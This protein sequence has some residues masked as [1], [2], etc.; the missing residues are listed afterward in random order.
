MPTAIAGRPSTIWL[1]V[2]SPIPPET[3]LTLW[4]RGPKTYHGRIA[5]RQSHTDNIQAHF[6]VHTPGEYSL[7]VEDA[8]KHTLLEETLYVVAPF[9][10]SAASELAATEPDSHLLPLLHKH[11]VVRNNLE[12]D[13]ASAREPIKQRG[14]P[15]D[16]RTQLR[17][18][19]PSCNVNSTS[20]LQ[21][22]K[23]MRKDRDH[24]VTANRQTQDDAAE[25]QQQLHA[26]ALQL[27]V[28]REKHTAERSAFVAERDQDYAIQQQLKKQVASLTKRLEE[29]ETMDAFKPSTAAGAHTDVA[30]L[31]RT[32][33]LAEKACDHERLRAD[34]LAEALRIEQEGSND[35]L[36]SAAS[37]VEELEQELFRLRAEVRY[38]RAELARVQHDESGSCRT[39][40][41]DSAA[42]SGSGLDGVLDVARGGNRQGASRVGGVQ[43]PQHQP[44]RVQLGTHATSVLSPRRSLYTAGS[45][46]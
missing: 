40:P 42:S 38:L 8:A 6:E 19:Q 27:K 30:K 4:L 34:G 37:C 43:S 3:P 17:I 39:S 5:E 36:R 9:D 46:R 33:K 31:E 22:S 28:E 7:Q 26:L 12:P 2:S 24:V 18:W 13:V 29:Y 35:L 32:L 45:R 23:E 15:A 20:Q 10:H 1:R 14:R 16:G 44:S 25:S 21:A 11:A 41:L